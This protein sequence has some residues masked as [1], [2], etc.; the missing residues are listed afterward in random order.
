[1][2]RQEQYLSTTWTKCCLILVIVV[3]GLNYCNAEDVVTSQLLEINQILCPLEVDPVCSMG[4]TF[5]NKCIATCQGYHN[6]TN[7]YCQVTSGKAVKDGSLFYS[8][9]LPVNVTDI[10]KNDKGFYYIGRGKDVKF[11]E[12]PKV[13]SLLPKYE[14]EYEYE[15][16]VNNTEK[17]HAVKVLIDGSLLIKSIELQNNHSQDENRFYNYRNLVVIGEDSRRIVAETTSLPYA[18]IGEFDY[19]KNV[20]GGC[21][22]TVVGSDY[23]LTAGHCVYDLKR[24]QFNLPLQFSPGR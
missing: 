23:V 16:E 3:L 13:P 4:I 18:R 20:E 19:Q 17:I 11:S 10:I 14:T 12:T 22:G 9:S 5:Q 21:T 7:G 15:T 8:S 24:G 6:Y 1:M 2:S